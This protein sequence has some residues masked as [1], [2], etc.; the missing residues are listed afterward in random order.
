MKPRM[1]SE[2][3][4]ETLRS[5]YL[6]NGLETQEEVRAL[7]VDREHLGPDSPI[8]PGEGEVLRWIEPSWA[9]GAS[10]PPRKIADLQVDLSGT[11]I[12]AHLSLK[13][14]QGYCA[15]LITGKNGRPSLMI[16]R[17]GRAQRDRVMEAR[18]TALA[19]KLRR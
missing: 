1:G 15:L 13:A 18:C 5:S 19:K 3:L 14:G 10:R 17:A 8:A 11:P 7:T 12:R 6:W 16:R 9:L 4:Q 2:P